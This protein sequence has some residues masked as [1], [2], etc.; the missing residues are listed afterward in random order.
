MASFSP[1]LIEILTDSCETPENYYLM[2]VPKV[3]PDRKTKG[4]GLYS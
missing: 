1:S 3:S 2:D 4:S